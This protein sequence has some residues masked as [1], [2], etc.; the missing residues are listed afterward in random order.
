MLFATIALFVAVY[1]VYSLLV[2]INPTSLVCMYVYMYVCM[3]VYM[4]V[5]MVLYVMYVKCNHSKCTVYIDVN[6]CMCKYISM[7]A[8]PIYLIPYL[9][10]CHA[11]L[12]P[13]ARII[14]QPD[15]TS[16]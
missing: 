5:C 6:I 3:Y 14:S 1:Y 13:S 9:F 15:L 8:I 11:L 12:F 16:T 2:C 7:K 10:V 4:Y